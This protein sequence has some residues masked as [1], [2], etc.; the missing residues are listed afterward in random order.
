M[1][2]VPAMVC[3]VVTAAAASGSTVVRAPAST[4]RVSVDSHG[5]Q[6]DSS[7]GGQFDPIAASISADGRFVVFASDASNLTAGDTN[8]STDVFIRDRSAHTTRRVSVSS[9][10]GQSN[11]ASGPAAI[12]AD[13]RYIAFTSVASNLVPGDTNGQAD[14][15][16]R[17]RVTHSTRLVSVSTKGEHGDSFS[18]EPSISAHGRFIA[19]SSD[20]SNLVAGDNN[21]R[22]DVFVRDR[23]AGTTRMVSVSTKGAK[24]T[25]NSGG[26]SI[27][28]N[29][30]FVAFW[31]LAPNL[32][33]GDTNG[34]YDVF[35]RD[36]FT[37]TT[38]RASVSTRGA[39]GRGDSFEPSISADGRF[40]AFASLA[41]NLIAGDTKN[42]WDVFVRARVT[43]TTHRVTRGGQSYD[44][45]PMSPSISP[46]GRFVAF[47]SDASNLVRGDTN[48]VSDVFVRDR[49]ART[50]RRV[51]VSTSGAQGNGVSLSPAIS[52]GGHIVVFDS[53][54]SNLVPGDTN[55]ARDVFV[56]H[57]LGP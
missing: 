53:D 11:G 49:M 47:A 31:S 23:V 54:A 48:Q 35:V 39:Q 18:F 6:G 55:G 10:G 38:R 2:A 8:G 5:V 42:S 4:S 12:S 40:V 16:L 29:G 44:G 1:P 30:R 52:A 3:V 7:S 27:S 21:G 43:H 46:D 57:R 22:Y 37:H 17:D 19:F 25:T 36:R 50:T 33:P 34:N 51:S 28:A 24:G 32:V 13:G 26:S 14:V 45:P 20:A 9:T 41:P 56:R 15:F